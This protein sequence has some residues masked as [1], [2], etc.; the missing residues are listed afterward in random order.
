[1]ARQHREA[2]R[3]Q[4]AWSPSLVQTEIQALSSVATLG[5]VTFGVV[6]DERV[7]LA[8]VRGNWAVH[9]IPAAASDSMII[10]LGL[11]VVQI[12]AFTAGAA[13]MPSPATDLG[14]EWVWHQL[15]VMGPSVGTEDVT[16]LD[17]FQHGQIDSKAMRKIDSSEVLAFIWDGIQ[18]A[19]VPTADGQAAIRTGVLQT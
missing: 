17:Q 16:A 19:G 13:S 12:S 11:I 2:P 18:V 15:I 8:R 3:R 14:A 10:A 6:F 1:M 9:M 5:N 7:T 4:F